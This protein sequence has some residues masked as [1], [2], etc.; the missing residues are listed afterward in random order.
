MFQKLTYLSILGAVLSLDLVPPPNIWVREN[1]TNVTLLC[2]ASEKIRS[3]SWSTPY[4]AQYPLQPDL[5]A[6]GGRLMHYAQDKDLECGLLISRTEARDSG[7]WRCNVGV[8]ENSEVR[9]ASGVA[10]ITIA[11]P[12]SDVYIEKPFDQL[13]S[14]FTNGGYNK[15]KC[16]AK[17]SRPAPSFVWTVDELT[18]N[19]KTENVFD[20]D[21]KIFT[22]I[23]H[24]IPTLEHANK[25]LRC[26]VQH[27]G[28]EK[29]IS[30]GTEVKLSGEG[31]VSM[32]GA[33]S[34]E[35]EGIIVATLA[36]LFIVGLMIVIRKRFFTKS[37]DL[38]KPMD[39]EKG[40]VDDDEHKPN[41]GTNENKEAEAEEIVE[42]TT[43]TVEDKKSSQIRSKIVRILAKMTDNEKK[44]TEDVAA[45]EFE[46]VELTESEEKKDEEKEG[47][48]KPGFTFKLA[49]FMSKFKS[50]EKPVDDETENKTETEPD[51]DKEVELNPEKPEDQVLQRRR[52]S[53]TPV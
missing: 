5:F 23:L 15:V 38:K 29:E 41:N 21:A 30:A 27:P 52:G 2:K 32:T 50:T 44:M 42:T 14:N 51:Q 46:K 53:E 19:H 16:T 37:E 33:L 1:Q 43:A 6:E 8:V 45:S 22:Q 35:L 13:N 20:E 7:R 36:S 10:N 3:C 40:N 17:N 12:P 28:L 31:R 39:E 48:E 18:L 25:T 24:F 47:S 11:T 34:W 9:T 26:R 4:G 49:S